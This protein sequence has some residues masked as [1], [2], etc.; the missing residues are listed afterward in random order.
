MCIIL[1]VN[2]VLLSTG[3]GRIMVLSLVSSNMDEKSV[4]NVIDT[5]TMMY[6]KNTIME[7]IKDGMLYMASETKAPKIA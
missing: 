6:V 3:R 1:A 7:R 4:I 2:K 5:I